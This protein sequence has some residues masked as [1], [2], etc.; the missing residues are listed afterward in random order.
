MANDSKQQ[1]QVEVKPEVS[2]GAYSNLALIAHS[3]SEVV[4]DFAAML[5]GMQKAEVVELRRNQS[6]AQCS[7][8][9]GKH[10]RTIQHESRRGIILLTAGL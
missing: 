4:I 9:S 10:H 6:S 1:L 7:S 3:P 5:P 8:T 2:K